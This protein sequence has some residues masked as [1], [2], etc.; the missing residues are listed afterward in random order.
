MS[1]GTGAYPAPPAKRLGVVSCN[2][3]CI[4]GDCYRTY[5]DGRKVHFQAKQKWDP[6][7]NRFDWDSGSC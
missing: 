7:E 5:D 2:S 1:S 6:F 4:N 3:K